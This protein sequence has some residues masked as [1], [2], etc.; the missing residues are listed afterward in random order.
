[1]VTHVRKKT[2]AAMS[3]VTLS[4]SFVQENQAVKEN[5]PPKQIESFLSKECG[6][7]RC[8]FLMRWLENEHF[9]ASLDG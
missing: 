1:M 7:E 4:F 9:P 5:F 6:Q 8:Y 3:E 2:W